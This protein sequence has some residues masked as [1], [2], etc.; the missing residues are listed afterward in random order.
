MTVLIPTPRRSRHE[1]GGRGPAAGTTV[2][3]DAAAPFAQLLTA[4]QA[5][6]SI[7]TT[8]LLEGPDAV[9]VT[10]RLARLTR[11]V[12]LVASLPPLTMPASAAEA[13]LDAATLDHLS[14]GR[15]AVLAAD[16]ADA[17]QVRRALAVGPLP[18]PSRFGG[19]LF[20]PR[21]TTAATR[22]WGRVF[23]PGAALAGR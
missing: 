15:A 3:L 14:G 7:G 20:T 8:A 21:A 17:V 10:A 4:A 6:D 22:A 12:R 9:A 13:A 2:R 16:A 19:D 5:A 11:H 1:A 18:E 23:G